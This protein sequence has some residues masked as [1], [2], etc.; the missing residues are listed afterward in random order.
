[1]GFVPYYMSTGRYSFYYMNGIS[2]WDPYHDSKG[3][4]DSKIDVVIF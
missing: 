1:M 4:Y 3:I 2:L